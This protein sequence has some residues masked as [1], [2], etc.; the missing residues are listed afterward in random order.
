MRIWSWIT[1]QSEAVMRGKCWCHPSCLWPVCMVEAVQSPSGDTKGPLLLGPG[2][3]RKGTRAGAEPVA[4][5]GAIPP[6]ITRFYALM[7][8][9]PTLVGA[10]WL[11]PC[12]VTCV[13]SGSFI[14]YSDPYHCLVNLLKERC[15]FFCVI[16]MYRRLSIYKD[17]TG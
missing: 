10:E 15:S 1:H 9:Y 4:M 3:G 11:A 8:R 13:P 16:N 5:S 17:R 6:V 7:S 2:L 14:L 12:R